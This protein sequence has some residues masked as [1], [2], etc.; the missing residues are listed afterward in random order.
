MVFLWADSRFAEPRSFRRFFLRP[1]KRTEKA[2]GVCRPGRDKLSAKRKVSKGFNFVSAKPPLRRAE[3]RFAKPRSFLRRS[4]ACHFLHN[5]KSDKPF[6]FRGAPRFCK[7]QSSAQTIHFRINKI[8][9]FRRLRQ[10]YSKAAIS[11]RNVKKNSVAVTDTAKKSAT[12]SA[13]NTA[14]VLSAKK[15]GK[16]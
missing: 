6:P 4:T 3:S 1:A 14:K 16:I 12:G 13:K 2:H 8:K 15:F 7:P 9:S 10:H 11:R 5:A